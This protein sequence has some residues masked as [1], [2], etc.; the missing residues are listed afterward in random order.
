MSSRSALPAIDPD[1]EDSH[2]PSK[3]IPLPVEA[4][5][6]AIQLQPIRMVEMSETEYR[7]AVAALA[8]LLLWVWEERKQQPAAA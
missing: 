6:D 5:G 1:L 3:V 7:E 2:Q 8:E 4:R